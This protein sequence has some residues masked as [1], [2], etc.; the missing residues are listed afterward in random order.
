[1]AQWSTVIDKALKRPSGARFYRCALQV[2]PFEYLQ[3]HGKETPF[4]SEDK[5]NTAILDALLEEHVEIIAITD[6]YRVK[7]STSLADAA[8][9]RGIHVF[10]GFEA[11]TKDGVHVLCVFDNSIGIAT[12]DRFIG[13]CGIHDDAEA[14]PTG[15]KDLDELL[16]ACAEQWKGI[17]VAAHVCSSGGLLDKLTGQT[18]MKAWTHRHLHACA[19]PGPREDAPDRHRPIIQNKN[20]DYL[21]ERQIAVLNAKDVS[22]VGDVKAAGSSCWIKMASVS[23]EGLRQAFLDPDSRIRLVSD[24]KPEDHTELLAIAWEG[25]FLDGTLMRFNGNLN[26][27]IGGRGTGKSTIVESIRFVLD[28][29]PLGKE[30]GKQHQSFI[31]NVLQSGTKVS[32]LVRS[33]TPAV[34]EYLV[35]RTVGNAPTVKDS[36]GSLTELTPSDIAGEVEIYGQHEISELARCPERRTDLLDRFIDRSALSDTEQSN[37]K[38]RLDDTRAR[39][40][41]VEKSLARVEDELEALPGLQETLTR[42]KDAGLEDRMKDKNQLVSEEATLQALDKMVDEIVEQRRK[43]DEHF[44]LDFSRLDDAQLDALGGIEIIRKNKAVLETFQSSALAALSTFDANVTTAREGMQT[45][46][47]EWDGRAETINTA[48]EKILRELQKEDID[49]AEFIEL[50][51]R[52]E[53]I[54]PKKGEKTRLKTQLQEA[55]KQRSEVLKEWEEFKAAQFRDLERA[56]KRV[57]RKLA[58]R[59]QVTVAAAGDQA[60]LEAHI[61]S[62]GGRMADTVNAL[63]AVSALSLEQLSRACRE[64]KQALIDQFHIPAAQAERLTQADSDFIM[65]IEELSLPATTTISLNVAREGSVPVWKQLDALSTG[66]KATAVLLLLLLEASGPLIVDQPEDDLDNRFIT[67]GIVPQVKTEKRRRQFVFATHNAN[68]P[69]LGDAELI[70]ALIPAETDSDAEEHLPESNIGSIDTAHVRDLVEETLEGG[71]DAFEMRRLKYGF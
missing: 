37:I 39:I 59:V 40:A 3:R 31:Q 52:I 46:R 34:R 22:S 4:S 49:G 54:E 65:Q 2:N 15:T 51:T 38:N 41:E 63:R 69:V 36:D 5:Y 44:P 13:D 57:S 12:V 30:T 55:M 42:Y 23:V 35:E 60:E 17:C 24:E 48:Q 7:T 33:H 68:L 16:T 28:R 19:L 20:P 10:N 45:I 70:A 64:G 47:K 61:K 62:L 25:G 67:E 18:A 50:R 11:V 1:M 66:Q 9:A 56:A 29:K 32:L 43:L 53:L 6:H 8:R 14:S 71:K 26:V 21:R 58:N 27:L